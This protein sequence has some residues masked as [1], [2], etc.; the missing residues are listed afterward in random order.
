[1]VGTAYDLCTLS[2]GIVLQRHSY[3]EKQITIGAE[4]QDMLPRPRMLC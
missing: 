1:M 3:L 2:D 4:Y